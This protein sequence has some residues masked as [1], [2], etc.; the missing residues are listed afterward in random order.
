[1]PVHVTTRQFADV[2]V[3]AVE[4]RVDYVN[5]EEFRTALMPHLRNCR[6]GGDKAVLDMSRLEYISSAGLRVLIIAAKEAHA[7]QG[8]LVAAALQPV[9]REIFE[10][11]RFTL[12]FD[13]HETLLDALRELSPTALAAF[14]SG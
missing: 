12:V 7:A 5:A 6:A 1:M 13:T 11:S 9:V 14:P 4:G 2:L 8:K 10:I 3:V